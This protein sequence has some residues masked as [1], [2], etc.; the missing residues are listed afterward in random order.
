MSDMAPASGL[1]GNFDVCMRVVR[2]P[3]FDAYSTI[4][5]NSLF[6]RRIS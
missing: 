6:L 3:P 5:R 1:Q 4:Y 2:H